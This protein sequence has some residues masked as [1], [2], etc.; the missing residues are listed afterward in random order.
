MFAMRL[1]QHSPPYHL[2]ALVPSWA[3]LL[4]GRFG[5]TSSI[6]RF[7]VFCCRA[8]QPVT[9]PAM[10]Q[11]KGIALR[12]SLVCKKLDLTPGQ[13]RLGKLSVQLDKI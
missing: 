9:Q 5:L 8:I 4:F 3:S 11:T 2:F 10:N 12:F 6:S 13:R 7:T 1:F